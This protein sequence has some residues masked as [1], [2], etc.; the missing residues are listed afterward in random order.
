M[1]AEAFENRRF[2]EAPEL[3]QGWGAFEQGTRYLIDRMPLRAEAVRA[4][5]RIWT[6][7]FGTVPRYADG[8]G[9]EEAL[10]FGQEGEA[11]AQPPA[12][13]AQVLSGK[14]GWL[15]LTGEQQN[16]CMPPLSIDEALVR[17]ARLVSVVR[18]SGRR[19]VVLVAPDKASVY[20]EYLPDDFALED[21]AR[22]AKARMWRLL[23]QL[24]RPRGVVPIRDRLLRAKRRSAEPVYLRKDSHWNQI[25]SLELVDEVLERFGG[26]V[27]VAQADVRAS[28]TSYTGDLTTLL[29]APESDVRPERTVARTPGAPR[30]AA[31]ALMVGDSYGEIVLPQLRP[32]F[33]RLRSA[34]WVGSPP[35]QLADEI[36]R[37]EVVIFETVE[38]DI[39][40]R[41][42]DVGPASPGFVDLVRQRLARR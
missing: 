5:T 29:G 20:P 37:A 4:N 1:K 28:E 39:G 34:G 17:W 18:Q 2:A 14:D 7:V 30:V 32:Y 42:S 22:A 16:A 25:G 19:A 10:A 24:G 8:A 6:D 23:E 11:T 21:C 36:A 41:A 13:A 9:Q 15:F 27:R 3:A 12:T 40:F 35:Q 33:A 26:G 38:R 31:R